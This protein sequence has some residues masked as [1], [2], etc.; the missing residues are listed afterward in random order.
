MKTLAILASITAVLLLSACAPISSIREPVTQQDEMLIVAPEAPIAGTPTLIEQRQTALREQNWATYLDRTETL[1]FVSEPEQQNQL[2]LET[3]AQL[4]EIPTAFWQQSP[5]LRHQAWSSIATTHQI[6]PSFQGAWLES[7]QSLFHD[8]P[9]TQQLTQLMLAKIRSPGSQRI[10]ILLPYDNRTQTLSHQIRAGIL[11]AYWQTAQ[12]H[13]L[14]FFNL[15]DFDSPLDAFEATQ[16]AGADWVI[17]PFDRN[18]VDA[19]A[20]VA[21]D[22]V[23]FLN[24]APSAPASWQLP[25]GTTDTLDQLIQHIDQH[26]YC[27]LAVLYADQPA[28]IE[29]IA[30]LSELWLN[31]LGHRI[32]P[33]SFEPNQRNLR[34]EL[35]RALLSDQSQVRA[36]FLQR[37]IGN[38]LTF[39]PRHRADWHAILLLGERE[40][41]S[42]IRPQ[43]D[44]FQ[45]N[46]PTYATDTLMPSE[47]RVDHLEPDL[48][49]I[50]FLSYPGVLSP[51][52]ITSPLAALGWDSFLITQYHQ[53]LTDGLSLNGA[54]GKLRRQNNGL[55]SRQLI[56]VNFNN[57]GQLIVD[58]SQP[59][60][61]PFAGFTGEPAPLH[62][63]DRLERQQEL[64]ELITQP[65]F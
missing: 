12:Q 50:H 48:K 35:G 15:D 11:A 36:N 17:G 23:V 47:F 13:Q 61:R 58:S 54:T 65:S 25:F 62:P 31:T 32:I 10:A 37:T 53:A 24:A 63:R 2:L 41:L 42:N 29:Q 22:R 18:T 45:V 43:L 8:H 27:N 57:R 21:N 44:F 60:S 26:H 49:N 3:Y 7:T 46:L 6:T 1:L 56:L 34:D 5:V 4:Q 55:L 52:L 38:S 19:L 51:E 40:Y 28:N 33:L 30:H 9:P 39:F 14:L 59:N 64:L 16:Q 20:P